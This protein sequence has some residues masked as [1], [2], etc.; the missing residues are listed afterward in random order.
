MSDIPLKFKIDFSRY[1]ID[2]VARVQERL[3]SQ[4][5]A[6]PVLRQ[7]IEAYI[8]NGPQWSYDEI[9]KQQEARTLFMA[10]GNNL[11]ALGRIVGWFR[12]SFRY[13]ESRW[14][15]AD[16]PGQGS[17]QAFV[18]VTN[19]DMTSNLPASD[20]EYRRLIL[21][22]IVCNF[23]RFASIREI[24]ALVKFAFNEVISMRVVGPMEA[25]L[26]VRPTIARPLLEILLRF[27]T[28]AYCDDQFVMPYPATLNLQGVTFVP[29]KAFIADRGNGHQADAG[30]VSVTRYL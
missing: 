16:R 9:L 14:F 15:F 10:K 23:T 27:E 3:L 6:S 1:R 28:T 4:F 17:D 19:A 25:E 30:V 12:T 7:F 26:L 29:E 13:D 11:D 18:W 22:K 8:R 2:M 20:A 21:A 5:K 24:A